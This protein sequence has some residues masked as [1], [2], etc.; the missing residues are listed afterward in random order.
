MTLLA[1]LEVR[2]AVEAAE[3]AVS[4]DTSLECVIVNVILTSKHVSLC[5][6]YCNAYRKEPSDPSCKRN[7]K[8]FTADAPVVTDSGVEWVMLSVTGQSFM[9]HQIR[10]MVACTV[11]VVRGQA[12][13]EVLR[14]LSHAVACHCCYCC[15]SM[16]ILHEQQNCTPVSQQH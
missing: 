13:P 6:M 7:M 1:V 3:S 5:V 2:Y 15:Y 4:D 11:D 9:L 16:R 10:K 12:T 14:L 8:S